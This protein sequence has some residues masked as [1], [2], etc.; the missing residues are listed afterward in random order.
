MLQHL[1]GGSHQAVHVDGPQPVGVRRGQ[2]PDRTGQEDPRAVDQHVDMTE[3]GRDRLHHGHGLFP[4]P[5][6][7]LEHGGARAGGAHILGDGLR[8]GFGLQ[9]SDRD[10]GAARGE[11]ARAGGTKPPASTGHQRDLAAKIHVRHS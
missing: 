1:P 9:V 8:F 5:Q 11:A 4:V 7:G 10:V 6:V 2:R 3:L